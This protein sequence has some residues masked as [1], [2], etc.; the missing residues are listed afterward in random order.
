[1]YKCRHFA[2]KEL[3]APE[4]LAII[5]EDMAWRLIPSEVIYGLD[6]LRVMYGDAIFI[7]GKG[8]LD[9]G[10]RSLITH[11]GAPMSGHKGYRGETC[12]DLHCS[13]LKK[14]EE[15][16]RTNHITL[17]IGR[18]ENPLKTKGWLHISFVKGAQNLEVFNP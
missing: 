3:V 4:I 13:D 9:A 10:V 11:T 12:F 16:V 17:G 2:I 14:L 6:T 5:S 18:M 8:L 1:M 15:I 7:N